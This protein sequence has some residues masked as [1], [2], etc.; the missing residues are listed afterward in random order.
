MSF[1]SWFRFSSTCSFC[2]GRLKSRVSFSKFGDPL[3]SKMSQN[4]S[5]LNRISCFLSLFVTVVLSCRFILFC[6]KCYFGSHLWY[7]FL[8]LFVDVEGWAPGLTADVHRSGGE[9][10]ESGAGQPTAAGALDQATGQDGR[11][12]ERREWPV[13]GV[14][15]DQRKHTLCWSFERNIKF[16]LLW[17][18]VKW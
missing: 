6:A 11:P 7:C 4:E 16:F 13:H 14:S 17:Y 15:R 3:V 18:L 12:A 1:W 8:P 9:V 10:P 5:G 2:S